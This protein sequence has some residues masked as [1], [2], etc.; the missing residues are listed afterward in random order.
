M[1]LEDCIFA[2][3]YTI[4]YTWKYYKRN[5]TQVHNSDIVNKIN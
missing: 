5:P 4:D 3:D 2:F 1:F